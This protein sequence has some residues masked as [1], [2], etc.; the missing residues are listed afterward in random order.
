MNNG[1]SIIPEFQKEER[2]VDYSIVGYK[3]VNL[4]HKCTKFTPLFLKEIC[5]S[6]FTTH[7][8]NMYGMPLLLVYTN[9]DYF[10]QKN[11]PVWLNRTRNYLYL[12]SDP[13]SHLLNQLKKN[14]IYIFFQFYQFGIIS[15]YSLT[16]YYYRS[17]L[18]IM[19]NIA[20]SPLTYY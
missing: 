1:N 20:D 14:I 6:S 9:F 17:P 2:P 19:I 13:K 5:N 16:S 15:S 12:W 10:L 18:L 7:V 11:S 4:F 8:L 3:L